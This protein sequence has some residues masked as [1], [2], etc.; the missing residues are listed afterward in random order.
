MPRNSIDFLVGGGGTIYTV[1]PQNDEARKHLVDN[2]QAEA[3]WFGPA[4]CVGHRYIGIV[5]EQLR[6][7]GWSVAPGL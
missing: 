4:V 1:T 6:D 2:V 3:Q 5:I 7:N